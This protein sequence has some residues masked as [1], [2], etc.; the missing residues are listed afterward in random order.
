MHLSYTKHFGS[1][2]TDSMSSAE[3]SH[4]TSVLVGTFNISD[5]GDGALP[6]LGRVRYKYK[7][8]PMVFLSCLTS[9]LILFI[10]LHW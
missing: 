3:H 4:G 2:A 5:Q 9:K 7:W 8:N 1:A 6:D 10:T